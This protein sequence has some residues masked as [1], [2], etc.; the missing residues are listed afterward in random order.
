MPVKKYLTFLFSLFIST[1]FIQSFALSLTKIGVLETNG[2]KYA[3]WYYSGTYPTL[4][5]KATANQPVTV[6]LNDKTYTANASASGDWNYPTGLG[7][8]NHTVELSQGTEKLNFTLHLGQAMPSVTTT[9]ASTAPQPTASVPNT[10]VDQIGALMFGSGAI[11]LAA[12]LYFWGDNSKLIAFEQK[13]L[14]D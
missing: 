8:G 4:F 1:L 12:Y 2:N 3:D 10:G 5:G 6:K 11:M 9:T 7:A 14:K 13:I